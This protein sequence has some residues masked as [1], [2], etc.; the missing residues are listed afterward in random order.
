MKNHVKELQAQID[1]LYRDLEEKTEMF[2]NASIF[3]PEGG[4]LIP[5]EGYKRE[6]LSPIETECVH[7]WTATQLF[8]STVYDCAKCGAKK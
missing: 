6:Y 5:R 8:F 4:K 7:K 2:G 3:V 1:E